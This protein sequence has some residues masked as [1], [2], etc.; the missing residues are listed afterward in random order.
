MKKS[1]QYSTMPFKFRIP[2]KRETP[3]STYKIDKQ[4]YQVPKPTNRKSRINITPSDRLISVLKLKDF[5]SKVVTTV[6]GSF[7]E[8]GIERYL[9]KKLREEYLQK[10]LKDQADNTNNLN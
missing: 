4:D 7:I 5:S 6:I 10:K 8:D 3:L 2:V 9:Q 1:S